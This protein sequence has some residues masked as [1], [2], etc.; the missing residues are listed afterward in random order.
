[1]SQIT[2]A[3]RRFLADEAGATMV[4]YSLMVALV[5]IATIAAVSGLGSALFF[6]FSVIAYNLYLALP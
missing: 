4:E 3:C 6:E 1:M 2:A 5:A